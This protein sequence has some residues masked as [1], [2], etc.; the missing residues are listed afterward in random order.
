LADNQAITE[1]ASSQSQSIA[2]NPHQFGE[3][4][5]LKGKPVEEKTNGR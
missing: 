5:A 2:I 4:R 1:P 3:N